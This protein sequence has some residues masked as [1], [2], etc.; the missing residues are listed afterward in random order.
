M[1]KE[2]ISI[3]LSWILKRGYFVQFS[4]I[5]RPQGTALIAIEYEKLH[6]FQSIIRVSRLTFLKIYH[7]YF[8][9]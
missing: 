7:V 6:L 8:D 2:V 4:D 1:A 9:H 3:G 5:L